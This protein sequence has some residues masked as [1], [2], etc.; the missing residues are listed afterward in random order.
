MIDALVE[1]LAVVLLAI[2]VGLCAAALVGG[3]V[4]VGVGLIS[5]SLVLLLAVGLA[6]VFRRRGAST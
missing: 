6:N 3:V 4:G 2:G 1:V 5:A